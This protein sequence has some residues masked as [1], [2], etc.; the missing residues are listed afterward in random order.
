MADPET[1]SQ[2]V[3]RSIRPLAGRTI[4]ISAGDNRPEM[5]SALENY[6]ARVLSWP[7]VEIGPPPNVATLD[8]AI[9]NLFGYDW[10]IFS[11]VHSVEY[12][13]RRFYQLGHQT[14]ELDELRI[15]TL[16]AAPKERL[17]PSQIH[18]DLIGASNRVEDLATEF[19]T[20]LARN[21]SLV[22]MNFLVPR[23]IH[24][25]EILS[26]KLRE[27]GARVDVAVAY[28]TVTNDS[29]LVQ[30]KAIV[31]GGGVDCIVFR[32]VQ[33]LE[34]IVKLADTADLSVLFRDVIA[35]VDETV[36]CQTAQ[37]G[38]RAFAVPCLADAAFAERIMAH[39]SVV[40]DNP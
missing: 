27:L 28:R 19:N 20:F 22:A 40:A 1:S 32:S 25:C 36:I 2:Q 12:F 8:E 35:A 37:F 34:A 29:S 33:E 38:L 14:S 17:E 13:L 15:W 7:H 16:G 21:E 3:T 11:N 10:I 4:L 31:R 18:V 6:G 30:L 39:F 26:D 23:A 24:S 5:K 9:D